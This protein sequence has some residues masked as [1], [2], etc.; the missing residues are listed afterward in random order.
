MEDI[1]D[2]FERQGVKVEV[3]SN[4]SVE[5]DREKVAKEMDSLFSAIHDSSMDPGERLLVIKQLNKV[6]QLIFG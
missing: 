4:E 5:S 1:F 2:Q 3:Q 6:Y